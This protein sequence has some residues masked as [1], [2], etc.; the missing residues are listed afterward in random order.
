MN[1]SYSYIG[2]ELELF[3][4]ATNWKK[5]FSGQLRPYIYGDVLEVGA[6][7]GSTTKTLCRG[8]EESWT[9]L[10]PDPE[11][12]TCLTQVVQQAA[13][14]IH[15]NI[16]TGTLGSLQA[17][18]TFDSILYIDVLEHIEEDAK[19]LEAAA[20]FLK[21]NGLVVVLSPAHQQLYTAFDQ[22]IGHYRRYNIQSLKFI[23]PP[24]LQ[25]QHTFYL[26]SVGMLASLC[27]RLLLKSSMPT[28]KQIWVWDQF[29][30]PLSKGLDFLLGY[31]LG[32]TVV[33]V[34]QKTAQGDS[35]SSKAH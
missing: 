7:I 27:N 5:Y 31:R 1:E 23:T 20:N 35:T 10:E 26:D 32:K 13:L 34:W 15:P 9:C 17:N 28:A 3:A 30:V 25:L 16:I 29:M 14:P 33:A 6:G 18:Q 11:L 22:A 12:I 4:A 2:N 21:P 19:E 24:S 8:M